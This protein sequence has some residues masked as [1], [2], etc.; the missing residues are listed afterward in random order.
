MLFKRRTSLEVKLRESDERFRIENLRFSF[1]VS[2]TFTPTANICDVKIYNLSEYTRGKFHELGDQITL[3]TGYEGD[4]GEQVL[5]VADTQRVFHQFSL[6]E[7]VTNIEAI[8]AYLFILIRRIQGSFSE[9]VSALTVLK[10]VAEQLDILTINIPS[11]L[12]DLTYYKGYSYDGPA[13]TIISKIAKYLNLDWSFQNK[14]LIFTKQGQSL[15]QEP[16]QLNAETGMIYFPEILKDLP[17]ELL[18]DFNTEKKRIGWRVRSILN[19][20]IKPKARV[21]I[22]SSRTPALNGIYTVL[23]ARHIGDTHGN[24][25]ET[26]AEMLQE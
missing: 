14:T 6:P 12:S 22:Y 1:A 11:N 7:I 21:Q 4:E 2:Q 18:Y 3:N 25:W 17:L 23:S 16:I 8:D 9:N 15:D 10:H 24:Q 26:V 19:P 5:F 13:E 20:K